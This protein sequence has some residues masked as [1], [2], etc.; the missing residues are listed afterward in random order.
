MP[1]TKIELEQGSILETKI[2]S[3]LL[4]VTVT[5]DEIIT[6]QIGWDGRVKWEQR[7]VLRPR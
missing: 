4:R 2:E 7:D 6:Q 3:Y 5:P 1:T